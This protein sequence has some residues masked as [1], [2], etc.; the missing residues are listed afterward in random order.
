MKK[1]LVFFL[2]PFAV[3]GQDVD[4]KSS[5]YDWFDQVLGREHTGLYNGKQYVDL[6]INRIHDNK[7]AFFLSDKV[8]N[9]SVMYDGQTYHNIGMKYNLEKDIL[10]VTLKSGTTVSIIQ[11]I[12]DKIDEFTIDGYRFIRITDILEDNTSINGFYEVLVE[13]SSFSLLK[14]NKKNRRKNIQ[15]G[16][17]LSYEFA[18]A[19]SYILLMNKKYKKVTTAKAD[20][21]KIFPEHKKEIKQFY[22]AYKRLRKSEPDTF[23]Q[24]LFKKIVNPSSSS[25]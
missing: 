15:A 13:D 14:K 24:R 1:N 8:M 16:R 6:D 12:R 25:I 2:L 10:L 22:E 3:F 17:L 11:L 20:I 23:M 18:S 7:N 5:Y 4:K 21:I 19:N 9:G